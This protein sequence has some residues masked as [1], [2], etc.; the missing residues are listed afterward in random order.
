M[1][2]PR[3]LIANAAVLVAVSMAAAGYWWYRR[4]E[5]LTW[6]QVNAMIARNF[7]RVPQ[8]E[9]R[10]LAAW[11][12]DSKRKPP[13]LL[14]VRSRVE[15]DVS[16]LHHARWINTGEPVSKAMADVPR[17]DPTVVYCSVGYRSSAYAARLI[18]DGFTNVHDLKGSIF[19]WADEGRPVYR[20]GRIVHH[21][22]PYNRY[23]G[24][25]LKRSLWAFHVPSRPAAR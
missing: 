4:H 22:H 11:L 3:R 20:S 13:L 23:W 16:H 8:M 5:R 9:I 24:Q 10:Q 15:Y 6:E 17:T 19:L 2:M 21:V 1:E 7:P 14:D 18:H 12:A 25:L